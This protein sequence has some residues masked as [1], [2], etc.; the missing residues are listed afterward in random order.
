MNIEKFVNCL[1]KQKQLTINKTPSKYEGVGV[2]LYENKCSEFSDILLDAFGIW[3]QVKTLNMTLK[4][5]DLYYEVTKR[6]Y[7]HKDCSSLKRVVYSTNYKMIKGFTEA[8]KP[9]TVFNPA[10]MYKIVIMQ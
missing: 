6:Y 4:I 2:Y 7:S 3:K 5:Q 1:K 9:H 8:W 10:Y